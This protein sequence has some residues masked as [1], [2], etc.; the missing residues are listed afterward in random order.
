M[1]ERNSVRMY[2]RGIPKVKFD[3]VE[4]EL[5]ISNLFKTDRYIYEYFGLVLLRLGYTPNDD[6]LIYNYDRDCNFFMC[7]ANKNNTCQ[8]WIDNDH[9]EIVVSKFNYVYG[10]ECVP[11]ERS[12]IGMII[13]LGRYVIKYADGVTLT[14]YLS[15]DRAKF[16]ISVCD[17]I[18]EL[19]I[20]RPNDVLLKLFDEDG[21]YAKYRLNKEEQL[22]EYLSKSAINKNLVDIYIYLCENYI[23][24]INKYPN[25]SLKKI[26]IDENGK[27]KVTNLIHLKNGKLEK[28]GETNSLSGTIFVDKDDNWSYDIESESLLPV[29]FHISSQNGKMSC[30]FEFN[31]EEY[32]VY[33]YMQ[34]AMNLDIDTAMEEVIK[35]RRKVKTIFN[36]NN[37]SN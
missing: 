13:S 28:Y 10:Y 12:E 18:L 24:D 7:T 16:I 30:S 31:E 29:D 35:T 34:C 3:S 26:I 37:D 33:R 4:T 23:D 6:I 1:V 20:D 11:L 36:R 27:E 21:K 15:R 14:R 32:D 9:H 25:F 22:I 5:A 2:D 17:N 8:M 19:V